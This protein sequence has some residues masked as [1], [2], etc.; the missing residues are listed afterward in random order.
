[1]AM[2]TEELNKAL[3]GFLIAMGQ[4]L[5]PDLAL[6]IQQNANQLADQMEHGG[7]PTVARLTRV[8][9]AALAQMH[10]QPTRK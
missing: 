2:N 8:F 1:M 10:T 5:P 9:G 7:E 4:T 3:A 6:R